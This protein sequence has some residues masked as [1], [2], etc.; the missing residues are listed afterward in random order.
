[1]EQCKGQWSK[2]SRVRLPELKTVLVLSIPTLLPR[3]NSVE[4]MLIY[5]S[6][7]YSSS[8]SNNCLRAFLI[9]AFPPVQVCS[10]AAKDFSS[11]TFLGG[12]LPQFTGT[13]HSSFRNLTRFSIQC[14]V[15]PLYQEW[16]T[17]QDVFSKLSTC[18]D[19]DLD[20]ISQAVIYHKLHL[21]QSALAYLSG[22][23]VKVTMVKLNVDWDVRQ[24]QRSIFQ[25]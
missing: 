2:A 20:G 24:T 13:C 22:Y 3:L 25:P 7:S 8:H 19:K 5:Q 11:L 17:R 4:R 23:S 16:C 12:V 14:V 6:S 21:H 1:M 9:K 10:A 18:G 15:C